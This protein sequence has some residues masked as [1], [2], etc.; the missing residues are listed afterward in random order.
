M[1]NAEAYRASLPK[2]AFRELGQPNCKIVNDGC[3][4]QGGRCYTRADGPFGYLGDLARHLALQDPVP[5][6]ETAE[7]V[8]KNCTRKMAKIEL[9]KQLSPDDEKRLQR[10]RRSLVEVSEKERET[11]RRLYELAAAL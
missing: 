9:V 3:L 6:S 8:Q 5:G 2:P 4:F 10:L 7:F 1:T 11:A